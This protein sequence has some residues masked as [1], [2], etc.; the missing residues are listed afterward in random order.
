[1]LAFNQ[2]GMCPPLQTFVE[3]D[4]APAVSAELS[5]NEQENSGR[6]GIHFTIVE[7]VGSLRLRIHLS[8]SRPH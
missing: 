6:G 5:V 2:D 8:Q 1:M 4:E 3:R 7:L